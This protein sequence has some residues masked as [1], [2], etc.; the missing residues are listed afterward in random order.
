MVL[1]RPDSREVSVLNATA[2]AVWEMCDG[3][4]PVADAV[5]RIHA[6]FRVEESR[7]VSEDVTAVVHTLS[8]RGLLEASAGRY[9]EEGQ[10]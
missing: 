2:A 7:D 6:R 1:Y 10:E 8:Q 3:S 4:T 5:A 9:A